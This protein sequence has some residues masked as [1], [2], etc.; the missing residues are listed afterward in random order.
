MHILFNPVAS[1]QHQLE[2][3]LIDKEIAEK[4]LEVAKS[5]SVQVDLKKQESETQDNSTALRKSLIVYVYSWR[6]LCKNYLL[7]SDC[8]LQTKYKK[9]VTKY[10]EMLHQNELDSHQL[11]RVAILEDE[12]LKSTESIQDLRSQILSVEYLN[13]TVSTLTLNNH[14]L[15]MRNE[16]LSTELQSMHVTLESTKIVSKY[17]QRENSVLQNEFIRISKE[18]DFCKAE[19]EKLRLIAQ[20][21]SSNLEP[22]QSNIDRSEALTHF[23]HTLIGKAFASTWDG[24]LD[25]CGNAIYSVDSFIYSLSIIPICCF[26]GQLGFIFLKMKKERPLV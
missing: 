2:I 14:D 8:R 21:A 7:L 3:A 24:K 23:F 13:D 20:R 9:L 5:D 4:Q 12:L 16:Q 22:D 19:C 11:S 26:I 25:I 6:L 1:L 15:E 18:L 17:L 10:D